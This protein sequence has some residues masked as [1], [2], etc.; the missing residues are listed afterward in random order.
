MTQNNNQ[1]NDGGPDSGPNNAQGDFNGASQ[2]GMYMYG[3]V[4]GATFSLCVGVFSFAL[5]MKPDASSLWLAGAL[6]GAA[7][8]AG[9]V[10]EVVRYARGQGPGHDFGDGTSNDTSNDSG[11]KLDD[12][13]PK[14]P[15]P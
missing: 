7:G 2:P 11:N 14:P 15:Q 8:F 9:G 10:Y 3:V 13:E 4:S 6:L 5:Y 1:H 12:N